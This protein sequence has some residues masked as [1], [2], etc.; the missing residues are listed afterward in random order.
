MSAA[1]LAKTTNAK[2]EE[3]DVLV[4]GGGFAGVYQLHQLR[5]DSECRWRQDGRLKAIPIHASST[6]IAQ[7]SR[8][9]RTD[10]R[11]TPDTHQVEGI[12]WLTW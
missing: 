1:Q 7:E 9:S 11:S 3:L 4:V 5:K 6:G 10:T 8:I 12:Q 2:V